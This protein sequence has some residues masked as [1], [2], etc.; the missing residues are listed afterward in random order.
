MLQSAEK[1]AI[2]PA[3]LGGVWRAAESA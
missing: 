1:I 3:D 2:G